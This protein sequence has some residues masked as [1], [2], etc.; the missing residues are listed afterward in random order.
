MAAN[1]VST[2]C[3]LVVVVAVMLVHC[4]FIGVLDKSDELGYVEL[5]CEVFDVQTQIYDHFLTVVRVT[6]ADQERA[7][8]TAHYTGLEFEL[9]FDILISEETLTL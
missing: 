2:S 7:S 4:R 8:D 9:L 6:V 1:M 5:L 3:E